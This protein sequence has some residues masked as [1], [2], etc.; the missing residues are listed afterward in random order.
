MRRRKYT[1][2]KLDEGQRRLL[3]NI[4]DREIE[5]A[6]PVEQAMAD[7][8]TLPHEDWKAI[9]EEYTNDQKRLASV[10]EQLDG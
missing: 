8:P 6:G 10:K 4:I 3:S 1:S 9:Q 7:D 5:A 2:I